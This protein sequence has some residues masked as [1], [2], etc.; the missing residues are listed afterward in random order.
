MSINLNC[1][2]CGSENTQNVKILF[3]SGTTRGNSTSYTTGGNV[4]RTPLTTKNYT[5]ETSSFNQTDLAK[6][7]TPPRKKAG[8]A[9]PFIWLFVGLF[10]G[11]IIGLFTWSM[12]AIWIVMSICVFISIPFAFEGA[13]YNKT[14]YPPLYKAWAKRYYCHK[15]GNLF[16]PISVN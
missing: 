10:I 9:L 3:E 1:P 8:F 6:A 11:A 7:N 2:N 14:E 12:S 4:I 15:C 5:T 16:T 13:K